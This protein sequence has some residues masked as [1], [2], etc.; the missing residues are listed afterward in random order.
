MAGW[1]SGPLLLRNSVARVTGR[2]PA[3]SPREELPPTWR[4]SWLTYLLPLAMAIP[5]IA[6]VLTLSLRNNPPG[7]EN[8]AMFTVILLV[9]LFG[10]FVGTSF[11]F[12]A[13]SRRV[14]SD[15]GSANRRM[16]GL[17]LLAAVGVGLI[18]LG[19]LL[20]PWSPVTGHPA[21]PIA[22]PRLEPLRVEPSPIQAPSTPPRL[23]PQPSHP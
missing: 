1:P 15:P 13:R 19:W 21:V 5:G 20:H 9:I 11:F 16:G 22:S 6:V 3:Q 12:R 18:S 14:A 7:I 8:L 17:L 2:E 10:T 23:V 4:N